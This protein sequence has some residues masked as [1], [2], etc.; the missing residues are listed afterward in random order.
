MTELPSLSLLGVPGGGHN[1]FE[2]AILW[3]GPLS[4]IRLSYFG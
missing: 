4:Q 1:F 2:R 3:A